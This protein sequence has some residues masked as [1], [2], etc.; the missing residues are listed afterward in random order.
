MGD[1][2]TAC[3]TASGS[4]AGRISVESV[5]RHAGSDSL[6]HRD[7]ELPLAKVLHRYLC[8]CKKVVDS[9]VSR[10]KYVMHDYLF[11]VLV[12]FKKYR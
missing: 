5:Q 12:R 9:T 6:S 7:R 8:C 11:V 2:E 10:L 3:F 1:A 4:L